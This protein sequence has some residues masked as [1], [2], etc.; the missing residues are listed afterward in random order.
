MQRELGL[1]GRRIEDVALSIRSDRMSL[2]TLHFPGPFETL[3][4]SSGPLWPVKARFSK[5]SWDYAQI[6]SSTLGMS[7]EMR[8]ITSSAI[9]R[10]SFRLAAQHTAVCGKH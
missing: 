3:F 8:K 2:S 4:A 9:D 1:G 6:T 7:K 5:G 10:P